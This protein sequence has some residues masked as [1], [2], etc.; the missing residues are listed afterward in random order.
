[1]RWVR[2]TADVGRV[3]TTFQVLIQ[4][5]K[6]FASS[7]VVAVDDV[8]F[9]NCGLPPIQ[10]TCAVNKFRCNRGS[11]VDNS[12]LCD[13]TDDCGDNSD[14][15]APLCSTA[16]RC[17]FEK[18]MC[19]WTQDT[20]D[21]FNWQ[22]HQGPTASV[23]TGPTRDHTT[24]LNSGYY[25]YVESS[26]PRKRNDKARIISRAILPAKA[27]DGCIFTF[28]YH[29][30]GVGTGTLSV[31]TQT[32]SGGYRTQVWTK[33][34]NRGDF[35]E[36]ASVPLS[37]TQTFQIVI[38][39]VRGT[40]F[41]GDIA[42]DDVI[43]GPSCRLAGVT[44][45]TAQYPLSTT[46]SACTGG[47]F[48][49]TS[50]KKCI[51]ASRVCD[52]TADCAD[53]SDEAACGTCTFEPTGSYCGWTDR[54]TGKY[55][56]T[57]TSGRQ[58]GSSGLQKDHTKRTAD[59]HYMYVEGSR[60]VFFSQAII[61][62]PAM[63]TTSRYCTMYFWYSMNGPHTGTLKLNG[64]FNNGT[65][66]PL[67]A[68][69]GSQ[70]LAWR[71]GYAYL[72]LRMGSPQKG[73]KL[74]F[75]AYPAR[76]FSPTQTSDIAIDDI[77]FSRC[78][79]KIYPPNIA[80]NFEKNLCSWQQA[81]DDVFD[82]TRK[83]GPTSTM[84]TGPAADHTT[85]RGYYYYIETSYPRRRGDIA[86]LDSPKLPPT[87]ASGHCLKFWYYMF[88]AT[89]GN[90]SINIQTPS[91]SSVFW[92]RSGSQGDKWIQGSRTLVSS[93]EYVVYIEAVVGGPLGDIAIDDLQVVTG[94]CPPD[95]SCDF[96][97][98]LCL[99][100]QSVQDEFDWTIG[101]GSTASPGTGPQYDHTFGSNTGHYAF[102]ETSSPRR[103]GDRAILNGPAYKG[104]IFMFSCMQF[105]YHM[106]GA[107]VGS[108]NVYLKSNGSLRRELWTRAHSQGNMWRLAKVAVRPQR[109]SYNVQ[110][111]AV[112]GNGPFGDIAI[113]DITWKNGFCPPDGY[114]NFEQDTCGYI[115]V[116]TGD[117][118]DWLRDNGGTPTLTTGPKVD[119]TRGTASG[120]YMYIETSGNNR[121]A[122][123][124]AQL[125]S[126]HLHAVNSG[127]V[128]FY[129][130]MFGAGVGT[131]NIYTQ[132][133]ATTGVGPRKLVWSLSGNQGNVWKQGQAQVSSTSDYVVIFEGVYGGNYTG[134]IAIDDI[135][136][137][138][139]RC[140]GITTSP[141]PTTALTSP[142]T[143][144]RTAL[145][146][147]FELGIC[148]W[149]QDTSDNFDW[150][151]K[152]SSTSSQ[153]TGPLADHTK[154][155][156][157]GHYMYTEVSG[158]NA[159][160]SA[161]LIS[162]KW[163]ITS[164]GA[165]FKFWYFMYGAS[166]NRLSVYA[167]NAGRDIRLW[168]RVG[169][170]GPDWKYAQ[171]H[172]QKIIG[173]TSIVIEG[174]TGP[175][176]D[177]DIAIDDITMNVDHCPAQVSCDFQDG[178]CG[179]TQDISDKFDWTLHSG[180]TSSSGTGP[181]SDHTFGTREGNYMYIEAS[182]PRRPNDIARIDSSQHGA[183]LGSCLQF[184]YNMN[185]R[186][187]G[188]LNVYL[189]KN[190]NL[191]RSI[192]SQVG[193]QGVDWHV[194]QVDISSSQPFTITF[195]A[196][197]GSGFS[198]DIAIDDI[199]LKPTM[200]PVAGSC[201]FEQDF[202]TWVNIQSKDNFD[203]IRARGNTVTAGTGPKQDHTLNSK[204]GKYAL[205][206]S[207]SPRK[208]GNK[209][210]LV[211]SPFDNRTRCL[212]FWYNMHGSGMGS[213]NVKMWPNS[214]AVSNVFSLNGD[215]GTS[216]NMSRVTVGGK[217][218][219]YRI[220]L[221]GVVGSNY[222]SDIAIDDVSIQNG[223]CNSIPT[224]TP[225]Q[226][227]VFHC[228][229]NG[230]CVSSSQ[231]CDFNFD[232]PNAEDEAN[233]GYDCNFDNTTCKW[234]GY[235]SGSFQWIHYKG[236]T[237][238]SNTGPSTDHTSFST[239]GYYMFVDASN[240]NSMSKAEYRSP[241]LQ[242]SSSTC[243]LTFWYHMYGT[244]IGQLA[245]TQQEGTAAPTRLWYASG[246]HGNRWYQAIVPIGRMARPF[247]LLLQATRTFNVLGDIAIDDIYFQH[248]SQPTT[249]DCR[250]STGQF[251][252]NSKACISKSRLCDYTDD[253]GDGSDEQNSTCKNYMGC[254]FEQ[255]LC[256]WSQ[257]TDDNFNWIR[258]V[259]STPTINTGPSKDHTLNTRSGHYLFIE[260]S[261]P[262]QLGD[263]AR[264]VS[265][266]FQ[267]STS[268]PYCTMRMYYN[269]YGK[270]VAS[271]SIYMRTAI[272]GVL[273]TLWKRT[274][275]VGNY[276]SRVELPL[277]SKVPFP[278]CD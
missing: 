201:A 48:Q 212:S 225:M 187:M 14:E 105:W 218:G 72:G 93:E 241:V 184:W 25:I 35:W 265:I 193:N 164:R 229:S 54:S 133:Y 197:I 129:Y 45:P 191:G 157:Q 143:Y 232:C 160:D 80:C 55:N 237:P 130:H 134:D 97:H 5:T 56:W 16:D 185:G 109:T 75:V 264:I 171:I 243:Q 147:D 257:M 189:R 32:Q 162:P 204:F 17:S 50:D 222:L 132:T 276:W 70:R 270:D 247:R 213:L 83:I 153:G 271:L 274:G 119:H 227:C 31:Y 194:S 209:A 46:Q 1:M 142:A 248:C 71:R 138:K 64:I 82:W 246:N 77:S 62:S 2:A 121:K 47:G 131:L 239:N 275:E 261:S 73:W 137:T 9:I 66:K 231:M 179:Y 107:N 12:Q 116:K 13:F 36:R 98:G 273:K 123:E 182:A 141:M 118:F 30:Y 168:T 221:E 15:T 124:K 28:Y 21:Q 89:V 278:S 92:S 253:C 96:E 252:C 140:F 122:G 3:P 108:L 170:Q 33:S 85:G 249:K 87:P 259:G 59:G 104:R 78:D 81:K 74:Q 228:P 238:D 260:A 117:D 219:G 23:N 18:S 7:G 106:N 192:W 151:R 196:I 22:R 233:C 103:Q 207:S 42:V 217:A 206:E 125:V 224:P 76:G 174:V 88:G 216:W 52:F 68:K 272:N 43:I 234:Q 53:K 154:G 61:Q 69:S 268:V 60:G 161:R 113:D 190:G 155:N 112:R 202:C 95:K 146:C 126:D 38:E 144:P 245:V 91:N 11:C 236:A 181:V 203:W 65:I 258:K 251:T 94:A 176:F 240:G 211:S 120:Y 199:V 101:S 100:K 79:P 58:A 115:N 269:M 186:T 110:I 172:L 111:E 128:R 49:C 139:Y 226:Q 200:C 29:M 127:C 277:Y 210:W 175:S 178:I 214:G 67:F 235:G 215:Q 10:Q 195:E 165:C 90:L 27:T 152:T 159:N 256:Q 26:A 230:K 34:G 266:V 51:P 250:G 41:S 220:I 135:V 150:T 169:D 63:P 163:S 86:R 198:S 145:Y 166:I 205:M 173:S 267:P 37:S 183:T 20:S 44:L 149:R 99:W 102:I 223:N 242:Q 6:N 57:V 24:N 148:N 263:K 8:S 136:I 40:S 177:G 208:A 39:G 244:G 4:A 255:D 180:R 158:R 114:C 156:S 254:N 188:R 262:R 84:G 19:Y 167:R